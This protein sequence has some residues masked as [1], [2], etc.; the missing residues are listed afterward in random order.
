MPPRP[1]LLSSSLFL[2]LAGLIALFASV[3]LFGSPGADVSLPIILQLLGSLYFALTFINWT[4]KDSPIGGAHQHPV[5]LGNFA[6]FLVGA[7]I[8]G[9]L[10]LANT[11]NPLFLLLTSLYAFF[12]Y[13]FWH[14]TF[15]A[16]RCLIFFPHFVLSKMGEV[17]EGRRGSG[18]ASPSYTSRTQKSCNNPT[19]WHYR[20]MV[21]SCYT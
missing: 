1:L 19:I 18:F 21:F 3:E 11:Q 5:A 15:R 8:L 9:K 16:P 14:L 12:A 10:A 2:A 7:L 20:R 13:F 6:H 17:A 4:A